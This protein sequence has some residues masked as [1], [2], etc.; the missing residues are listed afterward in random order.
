[1]MPFFHAATCCRCYVAADAM[2]ALRYAARYTAPWRC[3][4]MRQRESATLPLRAD[5]F[6][7]ELTN[8]LLL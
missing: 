2:R 8:Y 1:M 4:Y 7:Y 6:D 5:A 3:A